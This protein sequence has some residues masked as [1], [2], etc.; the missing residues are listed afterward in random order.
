MLLGVFWR[1]RRYICP[2][3]LRSEVYALRD[4]HDHVPA[5]QQVML[6]LQLNMGLLLID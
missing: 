3:L 4:S 1:V 6:G 2:L 5:L